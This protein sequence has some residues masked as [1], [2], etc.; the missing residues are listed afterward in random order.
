MKIIFNY[1]FRG[2]LFT[3]PLFATFYVIAIIINWANDTLNTILFSWLPIEI[4]GL[5]I[6]SA[7]ILI[8]LLGFVI[9]Q[10]F[11]RPLFTYLERLLA[12]IP[13][14]KIIYT[15]FKDF[16]EAFVGDKRRFN[17]PVIVSLF[18]GVDRVGFITELDLSVLQV[19]NRVAVYCPHSYNFS[20]NLFLVEPSRIKPLKID[21]SDAMK[22]A[23]SAGVTQIEK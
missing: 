6:I 17:Q 22:F 14:V 2:L 16:T 3:F 12:K 5:G 1:F 8:I 15:S 21:S 13:L 10:A 4:P 18:D 20:G 9:T 19:E 23:V 11:A 7:F